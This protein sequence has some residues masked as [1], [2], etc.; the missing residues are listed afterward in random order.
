MPTAASSPRIR[1]LDSATIDQIAAGEVVERP[2]SVVKEL[3]ENAL[4]AGARRIEVEIHGAGTKRIAVRDDG[5]GM[6]PD[7]VR[8]AVQRHATSKLSRSADLWS[9]RTLGF[10]GEALPSILSVSRFSLSS[11]AEGGLRYRVEYE[12]PRLRH[13][14][15]EPGPKGTEVVVDDLFFNTPA[16]LK[17]LRS[18][19]TELNACTEV[20]SRLALAYPDVRFTLTHDGRTVLT[21]EGSGDLLTTIGSVW[22]RELA[23]G[24]AEIEADV[25]GVRVRG[26]VSP[27]HLTKSTRAF[28]YVAVNSRPVKTRTLTAAVDQA[29]RSLAP[30]RRFPVVLLNL[31]VDPSRIDVNVSPTK[32]EIR[33]Q[34]EGQAF[35]SVYH[36][37]RDG[38]ML[39]GMIPSAATI[40]TV[41]EALASTRAPEAPAGSYGG[42]GLGGWSEAEARLFEAAI[43]SQMPLPSVPSSTSASGDSVSA[44]ELDAR[45]PESPDP[46]VSDREGVPGAL[47]GSQLPFGHLLEDLRVIGQAMDTFIIAECRHGLVIVDQHVAHERVLYEYL[48]GLK[49]PSSIEKQGLLTPETL[50]LD[51]RA[52]FALTERIDDIRS[53]GFEIEPFGG[54]SFL[55]R[56]V[57]A[58]LRRKNALRVLRDLAE[59]LAESPDAT[60]PTPSREQVWIMS[61]CRM[62]VKAGD[63][64]SLAEMEK[65]LLD[66]ATTENPYL[67]PH[68]RPIT[69]TLSVADLLRKFK[70][71]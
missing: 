9:V 18:P 16:R 15:P 38:L 47:A 60:R 68:G 13:E 10:R 29:Y 55:V 43:R 19:A 2:A 31:D 6:G 53:V 20:V 35:D 65:L 12:G 8:L 27:P 23:K 59:E 41:N 24:L 46:F 21:T 70:R 42:R 4:D 30:D 61:A 62:A 26:F 64:L 57:P 71:T 44:A 51:R 22:G 39:H 3:C 1:L 36:A 11:G 54:D 17:F 63:S 48:C 66:L 52:A 14:G 28:Q 32:T 25:A 50:E 67:C 45:A 37:I 33:F 58:A 56:A 69:I 5:A 7:E 40:A 49:G 34:Q